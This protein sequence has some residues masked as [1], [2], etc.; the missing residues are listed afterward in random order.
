MIN[1]DLFRA[2]MRQ[3]GAG[4]TVITVGE[5]NSSVHGMTANSFTPV[6]CDPPLLLFCIGRTNDT[7][8]LLTCGSTVGI[9]LLSDAQIELSTRFASKTAIRSRFD[10]L[11]WFRGVH[12]ATL[13][14]ECAAVLEAAISDIFDAGDHTIFLGQILDAT[15]DVTKKPLVYSQGKYAKLDPIAAPIHKPVTAVPLEAGR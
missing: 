6:S 7:H 4:V 9:N 3:W 13:F 8:K 11:P 5:P 1:G 2:T 10:D 14:R 12:G 15:P